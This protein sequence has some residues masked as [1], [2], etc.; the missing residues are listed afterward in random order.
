MST[1][2]SELHYNVSVCDLEAT[3]YDR[4]Y[5]QTL[6]VTGAPP[7]HVRI[8]G[9]LHIQQGITSR[10]AT[11]LAD[12]DSTRTRTHNGRPHFTSQI[13]HSVSSYNMIPVW[14][15]MCSADFSLLCIVL[16]LMQLVLTLQYGLGALYWAVILRMLPASVHGS[17]M[18][19]SNGT[20]HHHYHELWSVRLS[21]CSL[22][23][24]WSWSFHLFL[25]LPM[26]LFPF[27]LHFWACLGILSMSIL[28]TRRSHSRWY[29][30]FPKQSSAF[31][32]A[33]RVL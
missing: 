17:V 30:L 8:A 33:L 27:G 4:E 5:C 13:T 7:G 6:P 20:H 11:R 22:P 1:P 24:R 10:D 16:A 18:N 26:L 29:F 14:Q 15:K 23:S 25:G 2:I 21:A 3:R 31:Q 28:S 12:S 9:S 32:V 19:A